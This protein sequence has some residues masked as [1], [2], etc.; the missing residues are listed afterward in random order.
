MAWMLVRTGG[1]FR[2]PRSIYSFTFA[3][4]PEPQEWPQDVVTFAVS[5]GWAEPANPPSRQVA[6]ASRRKKKPPAVL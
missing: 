5:K 4:G 3:A 6:T 1:T 2:R